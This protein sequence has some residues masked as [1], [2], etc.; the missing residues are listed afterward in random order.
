MTLIQFVVIMGVSKSQCSVVPHHCSC[1]ICLIGIGF[2]SMY[3]VFL[4]NIC[5]IFCACVHSHMRV[6]VCV[7]EC[8]MFVCVCVFSICYVYA[9]TLIS[10]KRLLLSLPHF[11]AGLLEL[12]SPDVLLPLAGLPC[13]KV[14]SFLPFLQ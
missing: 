6:C 3:F 10:P 9:G 12:L 1:Q 4:K 13:R 5:F 14:L 7:Y 2:L 11:L 8:G